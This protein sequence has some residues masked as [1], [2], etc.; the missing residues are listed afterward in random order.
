[1]ATT[2][3]HYF[4]NTLASNWWGA[5]TP[6]PVI[7]VLVDKDATAVAT[8]L[9]LNTPPPFS[10]SQQMDGTIRSWLKKASAW[11]T[12]TYNG[13]PC[14]VIQSG[15]EKLLMLSE[16]ILKNRDGMRDLTRWEWLHTIVSTM[17]LPGL[18]VMTKNQMLPLQRDRDIFPDQYAYLSSSPSYRGDNHIFVPADGDIWS[19][20]SMDEDYCNYYDDP[21]YPIALRCILDVS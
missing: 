14:E 10:I 8:T 12:C 4:D 17:W 13:Y 2:V 15:K 9:S 3:P 6:A 16:V 19:D 21:K 1:M 11:W 20:C 5:W 7:S 18:K